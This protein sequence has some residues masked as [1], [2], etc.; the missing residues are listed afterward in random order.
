MT[1]ASATIS[2]TQTAAAARVRT[3][4]K[5]FRRSGA[6]FFLDG[7]SYGPFAPNSRG[8]P[9]PEDGQLSRDLDHIQSLGYNTIRLYELPDET[10]L[11][12]T[13]RRGLHLLVGI[14]WTDHVDF[15]SDRSLRNE[16]LERVLAAVR[17][18]AAHEHIAAFLIGNEIEKTL[19]RWMGPKQVRSFLEKMI[20][21]ARL[22]APQCLFAYATYPSTEYLIPRNA[23]FLAVNV[24]LEKEDAFRKYLL[25]LQNLAGSKPVVITE[26]G[27]D[28]K[29]NGQT[30]QAE[31]MRWQSDACHALG[32][33][34]SVW[35]S[36]TD[37]WER[38]GSAVT[39]WSF[40]LVDGARS[41]RD[42]CA[43]RTSLAGGSK[44][45][46]SQGGPRFSVI[47]CTRN[48]ANTL[49][50]CL[51]SLERQTW[52]NRE[53]IV[54]DDGSTDA[55]AEIARSF[56]RVVYQHQAPAGLSAA[57]NHGMEL[58]TGDIL[59]YTDDDCIADEDWLSHLARAFDDPRWVAAGGPNIP[60][61]PRNQIESLVAAAPGAPT[62]VLLSDEEAEHLPGCNLAIRK[63]AL[64]KLGG[65]KTDFTTAG[66][67]VDVCWRLREAG[68]ALRFVPA[69]M[70]WHHRRF[71]VRAYLRQQS[72]Y[73]KAEALLMKHHPSRFGPLGGA[74]WRGAIYGD[75]LG[76]S[77]PE[78]GSIYHGPFGFAPFQAV[79][80]QGIVPWWDL[81]SG[82]LWIAL[83][84]LSLAFHAPFIAAA[85]AAGAMIAAFGRAERNAASAA[86][87]ALS[88]RALLWLLCWLQPIVREWSRLVGM[89]RLGSRP[90]FYPSLPEIIIPGRPR[91]LSWTAERLSFWSESGVGR[92]AWLEEFRKL[93][94]EK[95][96]AHREDDGWR[97]FDVEL[98]PSSV[99]TT[100]VKSV[101]EYHGGQRMLTRV[102]L[103]RRVS[104]T[105]FPLL[106]LALA[107][108]GRALSSLC[109]RL[110]M[111]DTAL[112]VT[113]AMMLILAW[114]YWMARIHT[115]SLIHQA[116]GRAG[117][118]QVPERAHAAS[119]SDRPRGR[120]PPP[121]TA[122]PGFQ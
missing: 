73:G 60:P 103:M 42:V 56:T 70:V 120:V 82:V 115:V 89:I 20:R 61:P 25:R 62:H 43:L 116:A 37:E 100:A 1:E 38:G 26:F 5:F 119:H 88:D 50:A 27:L 6:K 47:V 46:D 58:A 114:A 71:T 52:A 92:E 59:A 81:F 97:L 91:K 84:L 79:Y 21:E 65:F 8:I 17:K 76:L 106:V 101:T 32:A 22:L 98:L 112:P 39:G 30:A 12:E 23:D 24:Y 53:I 122:S 111:T 102:G 94:S 90:S 45:T 14:P 78:E 107:F 31:A 55:T 15:L 118:K 108:A 49:R 83:A 121:H 117:L 85:L 93:L 10:V 66:D 109:T 80:P 63:E 29:S 95:Q 36:Y 75:G 48:G 113:A 7:V 9:F 96:T 4:G 11:R 69:A 51:E 57:R 34:G 44:A 33:A 105:G 67:D 35:F 87:A 41:G 2:H 18:L 16:A 77:E 110:G 40:G 3:A 74:R 99:I 54:M 68:G 72:G 19:V 28:V 64:Q 86:R 104:R 13:A